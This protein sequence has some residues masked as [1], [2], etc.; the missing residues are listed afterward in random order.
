MSMSLPLRVLVSGSRDWPFEWSGLIHD[1][2]DK[3]PRRAV[4]VHGLYP[5]GVDAYAEDWIQ[6]NG[7]EA[8]R[9]P[10]EWRKYGLQAGPI[11]NQQMLD[12]IMQDGQRLVLCFFWDVETS[13][14][15]KGMALLAAK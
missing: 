13:K 9:F 3:L 6:S 11:R 5:G 7:R 15:T 14:G 1:K 10:A 12:H 4:I 2:L 8:D